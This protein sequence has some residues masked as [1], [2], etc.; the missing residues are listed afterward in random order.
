MLWRA[1]ETAAA[2]GVGPV[3]LWCNPSSSH[4]YLEEIR[5]RF[6]ASLHV[7]SGAN[8]GERMHRALDAACGNGSGAV[9]IGTDCPFLEVADLHEAAG[10]LADDADAVLGPAADGGYYLIGMRRSDV[11]AFSDIEWGSEQVL[12][13]TR[14]R[15]RALRWRW[16]ELSPR[17]DVDRPEDLEALDNLLVY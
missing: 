10:A 5:H 4:P 17:T 16:H 2:A 13:V 1:V 6:G 8:L 14:E 11:Q 7:Q 15:F 12:A 3:G 9:L